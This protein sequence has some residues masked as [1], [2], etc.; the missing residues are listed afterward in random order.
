[1]IFFSKVQ[2]SV[3]FNFNILMKAQATRVEELENSN[4]SM[5]QD[6]DSQVKDIHLKL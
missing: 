3:F 1:M 2:N 5:L 6:K 4:N